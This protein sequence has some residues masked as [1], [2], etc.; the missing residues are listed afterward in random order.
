MH[1]IDVDEIN[2][3]KKLM[4][5]IV[6]MKR[7]WKRTELSGATFVFIFLCGRRNEYRNTENKYKNGYFQKQTWN[8]YGANT[9]EKR[10]IIGTKRPP[11]LCRKTQA[12]QVNRKTCSPNLS[13]LLSVIWE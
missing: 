2:G 7:K 3:L 1:L 10:M 12:S 9:D 6:G 8:E 11:E 5:S 13:R 4:V